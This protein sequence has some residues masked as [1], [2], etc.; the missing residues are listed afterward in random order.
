VLWVCDPMHGNTITT[1]RGI[2]TRVFDDVLA[3]LLESFDIHTAHNS[4]LGGVHI[5][6]TGEDVTECLGGATGLNEDDLDKRYESLCDPRLNYDQALEVAFALA[7]KLQ[8]AV[9]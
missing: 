7:G 6:M 3:E 2:K 4:H 5:E 1:A 8:A 9:A